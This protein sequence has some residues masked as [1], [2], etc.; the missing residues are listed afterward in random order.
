MGDDYEGDI[1][2]QGLWCPDCGLLRD[3]DDPCEE[4]GSVKPPIKRYPYDGGPEMH[5]HVGGDIYEQS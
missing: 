4:C 2:Y 3:N 1:P 5:H